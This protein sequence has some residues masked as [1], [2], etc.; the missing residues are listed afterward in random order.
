MRR[1]RSS[2]L[3]AAL[4]A[5]T[6]AMSG[7]V[8]MPAAVS[9][10]SDGG[11]GDSGPEQAQQADSAG[12]LNFAVGGVTYTAD[13]VLESDGATSLAAPPETDAVD[14]AMVFD[15]M[16]PHCANFEATY[17]DTMH[18]LVDRGEITLTVYPIAFVVKVPSQRSANA[19]IAVASFHP[20]SAREFQD[21]LLAANLET[22]SNGLG[23]EDLIELA[24]S[25][26][27]SSP[28]LETAIREQSY[29]D[30]V[31]TITSQLLGQTFPGSS[32]TVSGTPF[33]VAEGTQLDI[34]TFEGSAD[35][36]LE[37]LQAQL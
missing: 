6:L 1:T 24:A 2:L 8:F 18:E 5:S 22:G 9:G 11:G 16:C 19:F 35:D 32:V 14:V 10:D 17:G 26:G 23:T 33:L 3:L 25:A 15:P 29:Q 27:A 7:C 30:L 34:A 4:A 31:E 20:E 28:E 37:R 13:G 12:P 36:A 21:L